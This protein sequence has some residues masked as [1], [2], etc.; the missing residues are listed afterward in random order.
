MALSLGIVIVAP[1]RWRWLAMF[2]AAVVAIGFG[3]GVLAT[4][5]HRPSDTVGAY[6]VC[7]TWFSA[8]TA[9]LLRWRG[10]GQVGDDLGEVEDRLTTSV[11]AVVGALIAVAALVVFVSSFQEEGLR[12]VEYATEYLA[13]CVV[14]IA[15]AV[16]IVV[17]YHQLL[18]GVSLDQPVSRPSDGRV[19]PALSHERD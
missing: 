16:V 18:C 15:L 3:V 2:V 19:E 10:P 5:W 7:T 11:A 17:G 6:L 13:V 14:V 1:Y 8:A 9:L 4:G 12:T